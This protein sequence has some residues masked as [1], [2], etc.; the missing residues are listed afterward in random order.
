MNRPRRTHSLAVLAPVAGLVSASIAAAP[1]RADVP[2][3][4][5]RVIAESRV[6]DTASAP[7]TL[8]A[9]LD[10]TANGTPDIADL[11]MQVC[12]VDTGACLPVEIEREAYST[13]ERMW[14]HDV[15]VE[16]PQDSDPGLWVFRASELTDS[17]GGVQPAG[18]LQYATELKVLASQG[19]DT[20]VPVLEEPSLDK[21]VVYVGTS[22]G[23]VRARVHVVDQG[24]GMR[25]VRARLTG[26]VWKT[27]AEMQ[28]VSGDRNDGWWETELTVPEQDITNEVGV[29]VQAQDMQANDVELE[30]YRLARVRYWEP[31][32]PPTLTFVDECGTS[33]DRYEPT[34]PLA[35]GVWFRSYVVDANGERVPDQ[36]AFRRNDHGIPED[37]RLRIVTGRLD[38]IFIGEGVQTDSIGN[39]TVSQDHTWSSTP[40]TWQSAPVPVISGSPVMG[41]TLTAKPGTWSPGAKVTYQWSIGG[42]DVPGA[43]GL[44][45][46]VP[47]KPGSS[48][49]FRAIGTLVDHDPAYR[50]ANLTIKWGEFTSTT[51]TISGTVRVGSRLTAN[52]GTWK[53]TP[54]A[55]PTLTY[56]WFRNG[57]QVTQRTTSPYYTPTAADLGK[58]LS[59]EVTGA[60]PNYMTLG[61]T[62][63]ESVAVAKGTFSAPTPTVTLSQGVLTARP[64]TWSPAATLKYQWSRNGTLVSGATGATFKVST[65]DRTSTFAVRVTGT[66]SGYTTKTVGSQRYYGSTVTAAALCSKAVAGSIGYTAQSVKVRCATTASDPRLRWRK[67]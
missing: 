62:S 4:S 36:S 40:C 38:G 53:G 64:G 52:P 27:P 10:I 49:G 58:H 20:S 60:R 61:K 9:K 3:P 48:I 63:A 54:A 22:P 18:T 65:A 13:F 67:V 25:W 16:F 23:R 59:F 41:T 8:Q 7:V 51:P 39:T 29:E 44:T 6:V 21:P 14:Y 56:R 12:H 5:L 45:F 46:V 1:V 47:P 24:S 17:S 57:V 31:V 19:N 11:T 66:K 28:L 50:E 35:E 15:R 37:A 34:E 43:T 30:V 42:H 33:R 26:I 2:P 55:S 32:A